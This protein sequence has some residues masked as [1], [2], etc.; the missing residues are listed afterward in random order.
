MFSKKLSFFP[1]FGIVWKVYPKRFGCFQAF[2]LDQ[3]DGKVS[4][5]G[6]SEHY[7]ELLLKALVEEPAAEMDGRV[8]DALR[9]VLFGPNFQEDLVSRNIFRGRDLNLPSYEKVARCFGV[10]PNRKV[11]YPPMQ[12]PY[13]VPLRS[14]PLH[15]HCKLRFLT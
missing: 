14:P 13:V 9:N 5:R 15:P 6:D 10:R 7:M 3:K 11:C 4:L 1:C 8:S 12:P 2:Y